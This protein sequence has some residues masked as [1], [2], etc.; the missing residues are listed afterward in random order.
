MAQTTIFETFEHD[1]ARTE[2]GRSCTTALTKIA[3]SIQL[4]TASPAPLDETADMLVYIGAGATKLIASAS[5]GREQIVAFHFSGDLISIP[6]NA[7]HAYTLNALAETEALIFHTD[8]FLQITR[9]DPAFADVVLE[10][11][12]LALHR[13][14]DK[15]V[16]LGRKSAQ[17]RLAS[18]LVGMAER[19]GLR[20][21]DTCIM[22]LPMSR[23]DIG[24]SLGLTIETISRQFGDLRRLG[25]VE[26]VGR[27][28]VMLR[29]LQK[30]ALRAGHV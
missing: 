5:G 29:D 6:A 22:D 7:W 23:R 13:S 8:D 1:I 17:E 11:A 24:D 10:K 26:T 19:I 21:Q 18:F 20:E 30:L 25:L 15:A 28:R 3:R 2:P 14:R 16:G 4:E 27:S 12:L 9:D